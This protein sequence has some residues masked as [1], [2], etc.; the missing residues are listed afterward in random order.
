MATK[1][2]TWTPL[3]KERQPAAETSPAGERKI[4]RTAR[5]FPPS[6]PHGKPAPWSPPVTGGAGDHHDD[7]FHRGKCQ[8]AVVGDE[9]GKVS[10]G[11][12]VKAIGRT[13]VTRN[14]INVDRIDNSLGALA[15]WAEARSQQ[16]R[17]DTPSS[18]GEDIS[19]LS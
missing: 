10:G 6:P 5:A 1:K 11:A 15:R 12:E 16:S 14:N 17:N 19:L 4:G 9:P 2:R 3:P 18:S 13:N 7:A 8:S